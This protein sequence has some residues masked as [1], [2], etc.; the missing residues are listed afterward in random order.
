MGIPVF[1]SSC[2]SC[3][4]L[5]GFHVPM[6]V[7]TFG[8]SLSSSSSRKFFQSTSISV[9]ASETEQEEVALDGI[10]EVD[11]EEDTIDAE[12]RPTVTA[13]QSLSLNGID[14][15]PDAPQGSKLYVGNLPWTCDSQQLAEVFQ[16]CGNVEL[17]EVIYDRITQRSRG[18]A[19]VTMS[20]VRDAMAA[21]E[22]LDGIDFGGR[23]LKVNFP[24]APSREP[25]MSSYNDSPP[26]RREGGG[27]YNNSPNK[28]FV[29]NLSWNVDDDSLETIFSD[30]GKVL[31]AKVISDRETGKSR[32][33]G[34]VTLASATEVNEAI[35]NLDGAEYDGR[36]LRVNLAGEKPAPRLDHPIIDTTQNP[37]T[38]N[39]KP[40]YTL[41]T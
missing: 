16:D 9:Y 7:A 38:D 4:N 18:F 3:H 8:L 13:T 21:M 36:Q 29:G 39:C 24:Q 30:Y 26:P 34:F 2:F 37:I 5:Q 20:T 22:K 33:F 15:G 41:Y 31:E 27:G 10:L 17:V 25:R 28:L 23:V 11:G 1:K 14:A 12:L 32:G 6:S 40:S 19:F 35:N